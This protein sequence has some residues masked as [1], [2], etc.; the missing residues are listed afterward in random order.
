MHAGY[1]DFKFP[2]KTERNHDNHIFMVKEYDGP[3]FE[4]DEMFPKWWNIEDIPYS[5]MREDDVLWMPRMLAGE[6]INETF[7]FDE[8]GK[9]ILGR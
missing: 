5:Q 2:T 8:E 3:V 6:Y 4:T 7:T 1:L 9:M